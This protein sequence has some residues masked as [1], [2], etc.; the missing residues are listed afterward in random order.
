MDLSPKADLIV[1][2][3][4]TISYPLGVWGFIALTYCRDCR[5]QQCG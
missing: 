1:P 2:F 5:H 3:F 4:K